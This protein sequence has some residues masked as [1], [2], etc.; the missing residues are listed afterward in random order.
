LFALLLKLQLYWQGGI[1]EGLWT[2]EL[3]PLP[4][5]KNTLEKGKTKIEM[6]KKIIILKRK[7]DKAILIKSRK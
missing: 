1:L 6:D 4:V 3:T 2:W 7:K 5:E